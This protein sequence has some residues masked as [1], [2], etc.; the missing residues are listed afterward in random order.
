MNKLND[1][2]NRFVRY[3]KVEQHPAS[4]KAT[5]TRDGRQEQA[6]ACQSLC[7]QC[8]ARTPCALGRLIG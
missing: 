5:R 2:R 7:L 3:L 6:R 8:D 4:A 1:L